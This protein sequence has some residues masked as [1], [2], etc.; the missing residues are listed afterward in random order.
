MGSTFSFK[1][2]RNLT[3]G[4]IVTFEIEDSSL[5]NIAALVY[6]MPIIF[7]MAG[8]FIGQE[9]GFSEGQGVLMSF[10]FLAIS[11]GFIYF[12]DKKRGEKLIDQ[13]IKVISVD[14]PDMDNEIDSCSLDK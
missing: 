4:D 13:K 5:L 11:F 2:D 7:M 1:Y 10:L 6:L 12:F 8:Y 3:I 14:K 9:L